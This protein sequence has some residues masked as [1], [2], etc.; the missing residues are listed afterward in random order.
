MIKC[1]LLRSERLASY[2]IRMNIQLDLFLEP[3][4]SWRI[5]DQWLFYTSHSNAVVYYINIKYKWIASVFNNRTL[6]FFALSLPFLFFLSQFDWKGLLLKFC[7]TVI[8]VQFTSSG[9]KNIG[10]KL[11]IV[12]LVLMERKILSR[13]TE[14][15]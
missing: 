8:I 14:H 4:S 12:S 5:F 6:V 2:I 7:E 1:K 11:Y 13:V 10:L 9:L 3:Y 15:N